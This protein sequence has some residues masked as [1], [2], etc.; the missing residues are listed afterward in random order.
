MGDLEN[1]LEKMDAELADGEDQLFKM[2]DGLHVSKEQKI[3]L[4]FR[5]KNI[6]K[7]SGFSN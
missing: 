1:I 2:T 4:D 6:S 3:Q 5:L 7:Y